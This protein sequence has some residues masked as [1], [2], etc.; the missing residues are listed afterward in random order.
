MI[1]I[2]ILLCLVFIKKSIFALTQH[3]IVDNGLYLELNF[4]CLQLEISF[5]DECKSII[6]I[7]CL[8]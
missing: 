2:F 5:S 6:V 8:A 1:V 7:S 3:L 4:E